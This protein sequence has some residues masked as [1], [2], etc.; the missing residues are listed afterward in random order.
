MKKPD[1]LFS[2]IIS[3]FILGMIIGYFIIQ[4]Y[5]EAP[6]I[7]AFCPELS[8]VEEH[9]NDEKLWMN[10][11]LNWIIYNKIQVD[12]TNSLKFSKVMITKK[13]NIL[14]C[15]YSVMESG[16]QKVGDIIVRAQPRYSIKL[17]H[18][19]KRWLYSP[20]AVICESSAN[21][22]KSCVFTIQEKKYAQ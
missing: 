1:S 15:Y 13:M 17:S 22:I 20:D 12:R 5:I 6:A 7:K 8:V 16:R 21:R 4:Y 19:G 3:G 9:Y 14:S 10:Q 2:V 11:N 18:I